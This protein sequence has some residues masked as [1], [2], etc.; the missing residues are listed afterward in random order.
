MAQVIV[1]TSVGDAIISLRMIGSPSS[2]AEPLWCSWGTGA[3]IASKAATTLSTEAR[4]QA[5]SGGN[6]IRGLGV[7]SQQTTSTTNDTYQVV[8]TLTS[9]STKTITNVGLF[10]SN[11]AVAS[12]GP[13]SGGNLFFMADS[14]SV[15]LNNNDAIQFTLKVQ[16][17]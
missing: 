17:N 6:V 13:P 10:D 7:S 14:L 5:T 4:S 2:Q 9:D 12:P 8:S 16:N 1:V 11:G 3:G 15:L